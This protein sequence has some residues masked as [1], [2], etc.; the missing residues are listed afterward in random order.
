MK[1]SFCLRTL[2]EI[3]KKSL[4]NKSVL[5]RADFNAPVGNDGVIDSNEDWRIK[6]VLPTIEYLLKQNTKII[7]LAHLGRPGGKVRE[8]LRLDPIRDRLS[9]LL[10]LSVKKIFDCV[11][12]DAENAI[13]EMKAGEILLLENLRFHSGEEE[14]DDVFAKKLSK[15]GDIY[16]NDAFSDCHRKHASIVGITKFL[17]SYAGLLLEKEFNLM[18]NANNPEHPA[19]AIIGGA[20]IETKLS[21][22]KA[23]EKIYDHILVGGIIANEI[24][25]DQKKYNIS[26]NVILPDKKAVLKAKGYDIGEISFKKFENF[27]KNA[28]TIIWNGPMGK[29]EEKKYSAGTRNVIGSVIEA[30]DAGAKI[31]IGGGETINAIQR[32]APELMN[33]KTKSFN[34]ST[35]GGA[36]L[37]F[38]AGE[39][40]PGIEALKIKKIL[41]S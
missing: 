10:N 6:A 38:L 33:K 26:P 2:R 25:K 12:R 13:G 29:F 24:I 20:K 19:V 4:K 3:P 31:L 18:E 9:E 15:L 8:N 16:I 30:H 7:L 28:K 27:I 36:M 41:S 40:L 14:N 23:L 21:E 5:L 22:V 34:I 37:K 17:P 11:G 32:F 39:N 1:N 35:G